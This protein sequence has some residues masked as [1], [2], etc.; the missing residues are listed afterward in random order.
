MGT[1]QKGR[2]PSAGQ[3]RREES[4][5]QPLCQVLR[6]HDLKRKRGALYLRQKK[7]PSCS[8]GRHGRPHI[9]LAAVPSELGTKLAGGWAYLGWVHQLLAEEN[10]VFEMVYPKA[11]PVRVFRHLRDEKV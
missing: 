4:D 1:E 7:R 2:G 5:C 9:R 3:R 6:R 11:I 8:R 10:R